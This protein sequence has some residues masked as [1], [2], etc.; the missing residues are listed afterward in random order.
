MNDYDFSPLI[1]ML[2]FITE[3]NN[4]NFEQEIDNYIDV[5]SVITL[6]AIDDFL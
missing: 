4:E 3:S 6:L 5:K 1:R 2:K